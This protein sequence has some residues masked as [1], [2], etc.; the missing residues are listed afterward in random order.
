M[1]EEKFVY[2]IE[3]LEKAKLDLDRWQRRSD[4]DR[5]NNPNKYL[6]DIREARDRVRFIES[7]LKAMGVLERTPEEILKQSLDS[8]F[9]NAK[10]KEV[11]SFNGRRFQ[12]IFEPLG[13]SRSG[14]VSRW[15][16]K[17]LEL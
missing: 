14:K 16:S 8:A 12:R 3:D 2:T 15:D 11:V 6:S 10:S 13:R 5:S 9:P 7:H 1:A 4:N 17:W